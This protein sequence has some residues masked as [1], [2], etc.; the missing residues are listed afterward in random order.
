MLN[1]HYYL[2]QSI[3]SDFDIYFSLKFQISNLS[4][5]HKYLHL[6]R[7]LMRESRDVHLASD[8]LQ[9]VTAHNIN[10][11]RSDIKGMYGKA[12]NLLLSRPVRVSG[13]NE[14]PPYRRG[15]TCMS[16]LGNCPQP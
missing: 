10:R 11:N 9:H 5:L 3:L 8:R 15:Y 4:Q 12:L 6:F 14:I 1:A 2:N 7:A 16:Q 13:L